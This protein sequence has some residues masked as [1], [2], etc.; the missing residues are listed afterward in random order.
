MIYKLKRFR[1]K[2]LISATYPE[3]PKKKWLHTV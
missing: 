2:A 3:M 1:E